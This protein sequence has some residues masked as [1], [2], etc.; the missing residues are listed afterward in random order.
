MSS[1]NAA[2]DARSDPAA[3]RNLVDSIAGSVAWTAAL[4]L[5]VL[6]ALSLVLRLQELA[7][8]FWIDEGLSVGISSHGL[9]DIPSILRQDGSPPLYYLVLHVW[10]D[11]FGYGVTATHTLS[12]AFAAISIPVALWA[13]WR[14]FGRRA[15]IFCAA[16]FALNPM[17]SA[18]AQETRMY[19]LLALLGLIGA[20]AFVQVFVYRRRAWI[21]VFAGAMAAMFYTH[22]WAAFFALGALSALGLLL[23]WSDERRA[24]A[25]DAVLS[26]GVPAVLYLP[27]LPTLVSQARHTGAPWASHPDVATLIHAPYS[28]LGSPQI[29]TAVL[30]GAGAGLVMLWRRRPRSQEAVAGATLCAILV[31]GLLIAFV[32]SQ[33]ELA[34]A[35]RY[36]TVFLGPGLLLAALGFARAGGLGVVAGMLVLALS[37]GVT[38]RTVADDKSNVDRVGHRFAPRVERGDVVLSTQ[39]EQIPNLYYYLPPGL[40]Y[41]S[42]LGTAP[43][44][45]V[46]DWRD[47]VDRLRAA[48]VSADLLPMLDRLAPGRRLLVVSPVLRYST[49][50]APWTRLVKRKS[51]QWNRAIAAYP[52][53][54]RIRGLRPHDASR[55]STVRATLFVKRR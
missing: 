8:P 9:G 49:W 27:W 34:W 30:L 42:P 39:P 52:G 17:L 24:L 54:R 21:A 22:N 18:Y 48:H 19:S 2:V 12:L 53:L 50:R 25:R 41:V 32:Y 51:K 33:L 46:M 26:F 3:P 37:I 43:D 14:L 31:V 28:M 45:R 15:G 5:V 40:T 7:G 10:S 29:G 13:G 23:R 36:L 6:L 55:L 35:A 4:I 1:A 38:G 44:P 47:A 16:L 20:A 11:V